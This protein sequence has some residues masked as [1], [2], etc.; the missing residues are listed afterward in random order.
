LTY[1]ENILG[2]PADA[3]TNITNTADLAK[4]MAQQLLDKYGELNGMHVNTTVTTNIDWGNLYAYQSF[5]N[6]L[7]ATRAAAEVG[8]AGYYGSQ[9]A[10]G[11]IFS[12]AQGGENHVAQIAPPTGRTFRMW[13]EPETGGEAY[14]P[15]APGK[16]GRSTAIL[17]DVAGRFGYGLVQMQVGG[18]M[19]AP[20]VPASGG[21][22][23]GTAP[24]VIQS[25]IHFNAP[26]YGEEGMKQVAKKV[27]DERDRELQ[28]SFRRNLSGV[29]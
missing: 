17:R 22:R 6:S 8:S 26:V 15:L 10:D 16:R 4:Y 28:L 20:T 14:I 29:V 11:N 21:S 27:L 3:R 19:A 1:T 7:G 2:I 18:V 24:V 12:Y 9:S 25:E 23:A 5:L 13:A